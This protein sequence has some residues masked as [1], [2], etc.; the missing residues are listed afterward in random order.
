MF[1]KGG[2]GR[3]YS[4]GAAAQPASLYDLLKQ[5]QRALRLPIVDG[6]G[7]VHETGEAAQLAGA[8]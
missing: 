4:G 2:T 5:P 3:Q 7:A 8:L 6:R 1:L